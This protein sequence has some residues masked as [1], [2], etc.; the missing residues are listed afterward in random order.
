MKNRNKIIFPSLFLVPLV[1]G[2]IFLDLAGTFNYSDLPFLF[3]FV[4]Y[5]VFVFIQRVQ[6]KATFSVALLLLIYMGLSY[7]PAGPSRVT[8]RFGEWFFLFFVYGLIQYVKDIWI[9]L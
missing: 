9:G 1:A 3:A 8:E 4:I 2:I 5:F 7:I 6:S